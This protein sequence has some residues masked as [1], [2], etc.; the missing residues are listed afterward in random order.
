MSTMK[1]LKSK[2]PPL[3][4]ISDECRLKVEAI[5]R[6]CPK[7][8]AWLGYVEQGEYQSGQRWILLKDCYVPKQ[9]VSGATCDIDPEGVADYVNKLLDEGLDPSNMLW[10]GHSH[11]NM[12]VR[13]SG[14]DM[15]T[16]N[17]FIENLE[18]GTPFVMSI[19]NKKGEGFCNLSLGDGYYLEDVI[20]DVRRDTTEIDTAV[21]KEINDNVRN[22]TY[23]HVN[24]TGSNTA[25]RHSPSTGT[26]SNPGTAAGVWSNRLEPN[27]AAGKA[28]NARHNAMGL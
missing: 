20:I 6:L 27:V 10:W 23:G 21:E 13:P 17:E 24:N 11:V 26:V 5:V 3:V 8:I 2:Q 19:H 28:G 16:F 15:D 12:G 18:E 22:K 7:E 25:N 1:N 14:T 9:E 4:V